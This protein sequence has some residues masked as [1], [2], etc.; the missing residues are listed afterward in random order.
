MPDNTASLQK[1]IQQ[2][3]QFPFAI[4]FAWDLVRDAP[5]LLLGE[6]LDPL[7]PRSKVILECPANLV[8]VDVRQTGMRGACNGT[9][10]KVFGGA[11]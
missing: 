7:R 8:P 6:H 10:E 11:D 4:P 3:L 2:A 1:A 9:R 5:Q